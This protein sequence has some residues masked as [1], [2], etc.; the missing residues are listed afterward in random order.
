MNSSTKAIIYYVLA[1][2]Y[3]ELILFLSVMIPMPISIIIIIL[4][5]L[6]LIIIYKI[7]YKDYTKTYDKNIKTKGTIK[8]GYIVDVYENNYA[9]IIVENKVYRY[10]YIST[11]KEFLKIIENFNKNYKLENNHLYITSIPIK[12]YLHENK[13]TPYISEKGE[14]I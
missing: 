12:V 8:Q 6:S 4:G 13:I 2:L 14:Q 1:L 10:N 11:N 3:I 9:T 5:L 7:L